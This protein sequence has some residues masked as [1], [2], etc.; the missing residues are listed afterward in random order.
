MFI[1]IFKNYLTTHSTS[2]AL[3]HLRYTGSVANGANT[4]AKTDRVDAAMLY[5]MR[6]LLELSAD[7]PKSEALHYLKEMRNGG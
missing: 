6:P 4:P 2:F 7:K 3:V 1:I 5:R